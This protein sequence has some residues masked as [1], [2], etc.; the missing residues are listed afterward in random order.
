MVFD[1][2]GPACD[3]CSPVSSA[4][5]EETWQS[6]ECSTHDCQLFDEVAGDEQ[7]VDDGSC[8]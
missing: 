3:G 7:V 2:V 8:G 1:G 5:N 4:P 6:D